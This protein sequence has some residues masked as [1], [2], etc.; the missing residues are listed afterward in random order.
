MMIE[1][2]LKILI[3]G[4]PRTGKSLLAASLSQNFCIPVIH[5]DTLVNAM[6][7][8][9]PGSFGVQFDSLHKHDYAAQMQPVQLF[10]K[11]VIRNMG[12]DIA[13]RA[14][15][16]ESCYLHPKTVQR[17]SRESTVLAVFLLYSN[18]DTEIRISEIR[19]YASVN[20][21]CWSHKHS[22]ASL[23]KSLTDLHKFSAFLK[24]KCQQ[25][26]VRCA[27]IGNDW[28]QTWMEV[29]NDLNSR[30]FKEISSNLQGSE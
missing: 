29:K 10:L 14:K 22:D 15:V 2:H 27:Y 19:K 4:A 1:T 18:F 26:N 30:V 20:Q 16:F 8:G 5:G 11:K 24:K 6:K 28:K 17:L 23:R 9:Y 7:N 21:H 25:H 12:K 3:G 13:Y